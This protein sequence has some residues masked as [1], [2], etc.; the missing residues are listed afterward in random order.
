MLLSTLGGFQGCVQAITFRQGSDQTA[1]MCVFLGLNDDL[2]WSVMGH[3]VNY[4]VTT[5]GRAQSY[6]MPRP[7]WMLCG[8][9]HWHQLVY[10]QEGIDGSKA[11]PRFGKAH[12]RHAWIVWNTSVYGK[13][14]DDITWICTSTLYTRYVDV[15][16]DIYAK[17]CYRPAIEQKRLAGRPT[18]YRRPIKPPANV[19]LRVPPNLLFFNRVL[20]SA[21]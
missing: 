11:R 21:A 12:E 10:D 13:G 4:L 7:E 19:W 1:C 8:A 17:Y 6:W 15:T 16:S 14:R 18:Q 20:S 9:A 3:P 2:D 5:R